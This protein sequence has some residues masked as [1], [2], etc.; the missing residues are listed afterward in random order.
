MEELVQLPLTLSIVACI[1]AAISFVPGLIA[2]VIALALKNSSHTTQFVP[3][4]P[5]QFMKQGEQP[6]QSEFPVFPSGDGASQPLQPTEEDALL[7]NLKKNFDQWAN[8]AEEEQGEFA[9]SRRIVS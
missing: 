5:M 4:D 2:L 6:E 9:S 3:V 1:L 8:P 7:E